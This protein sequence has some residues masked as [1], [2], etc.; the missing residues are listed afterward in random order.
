MVKV[1]HFRPFF[2]NDV[3]ICLYEKRLVLPV[4]FAQPS[5]DAVSDYGVA[6]LL[7]HG[8]AQPGTTR[9]R[10]LPEQQKVRRVHLRSA[11]VELQELGAFAQA[12][13]L[14]KN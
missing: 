3:N 12:F 8:K 13:T 7:A 1:K 11:R 6:N 2:G 10:I 14:G 4:K 9:R 5:L